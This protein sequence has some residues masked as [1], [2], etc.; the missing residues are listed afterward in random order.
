MLGLRVLRGRVGSQVLLDLG[1]RPGGSR[2][3]APPSAHPRPP[4]LWAHPCQGYPSSPAP[5]AAL[6]TLQHNPHR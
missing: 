2:L 3:L 5:I 4:E 6:S 1:H